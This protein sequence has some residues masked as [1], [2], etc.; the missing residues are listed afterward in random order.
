MGL[1]V[2]SLDCPALLLEVRSLPMFDQI[3]GPRESLK[4]PGE[5]GRRFVSQGAVLTN[6]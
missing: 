6:V 5:Q 4:F 2:Q 3:G 1:Q